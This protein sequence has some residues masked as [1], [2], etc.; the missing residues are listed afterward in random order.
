MKWFALG[1]GFV[2]ASIFG[3]WVLTVLWRWFIIPTFGL[4]ALS[5]PLAIGI[6]L[7]V[8]HLVLLSQPNTDKG[9]S[10]FDNLAESLVFAM[11]TR[12]L[13]LISGFILHQW[14]V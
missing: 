8:G 1:V 3:G 6:N 14:F 5:I 10:I 7:V 11:T 12:T 13:F 2:V 9:K 4:P